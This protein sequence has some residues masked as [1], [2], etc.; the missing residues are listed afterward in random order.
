MD[1]YTERKVHKPLALKLPVGAP[2]TA[3]FVRFS[4]VGDSAGI[5]AQRAAHFSIYG[6]DAAVA[7]MASIPDDAWDPTRPEVGRAHGIVWLT[8]SDLHRNA[9]GREPVAAIVLVGGHLLASVT[10]S[11]TLKHV[12][13]DDGED[14]NGVT[15]LLL[16]LINHY[17]SLRAIRWADDVTRAQRDPADWALIKNKC[18]IRQITMVVGGRSY[19]MQDDGAEM[20]LGALGLVGSSDDPKRRRRLTGKRL[21]KYRT[22][23]AGIAESQL[24]HGW[25]FLRDKHGRP[26]IDDD[27]GRIPEAQPAMI[28]VMRSLYEAHAGGQTYRE[29][30]EQLV[31][32]E[33][34]GQLVRRDHTDPSSTYARTADDSLARYD[35]A[36][37]FFVR[38]SFRPATPPSDEAIECY[39]A[40]DDPQAVFD[41]ETRLYIAKVELVRTGTYF[42]RLRNDIRGRGL[43]LDGIPATYRDDQDEYGWFDVLSSPWSWPCDVEQRE[44]VRF[45]LTDSTCRQVAGRLLRELRRSSGAAGGGRSH[46]TARPRA[47]QHFENWLTEPGGEYADEPTE[48]GVEARENNSGRENF[49]LLFR[50][51]SEGGG[52]RGRR[53]WGFVGTGQRRADH[54][55]ATGNLA[56]LCASVSSSLESASRTLA[57]PSRVLLLHAVAPTEPVLDRKAALRHNLDRELA[58]MAEADRLAEGHRTMAALVAEDDPVEARK[59]AAAAVEAAR[60]A[61]RLGSR[62]EALQLELADAATPAGQPEE[63]VANVGLVPYVVVGLERAAASGGRSDERLA[64]VCGELFVGWEFSVVN[65]A[66]QWSCQCVLPLESGRSAHLPLAGTVRNV[67]TRSGRAFATTEVVMRHLMEEGQSVDYVAAVLD[68]SRSGLLVRRIMPWLASNGVV[69]RGAKCALVDH[70]LPAVRRL[71]YRQL[72]GVE[73][74]VN[75]AYVAR[76]QTTYT[77]PQLSW[78]D[79]AVPDDCVWIAAVLELLSRDADAHRNGLPLLD[80]ALAVGRTEREVRALVSPLDRSA[81]GFVRPR[82]LRYADAARSRVATLKCP[83]KS[84]RGRH[85]ADHV[86]LLPEVAA[87]GWGVICRKCRRV[88]ATTGD[89]PLTQFPEAYLRSWSRTTGVKSLRR[90]RQ[91]L[92]A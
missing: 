70:P 80:V 11:T 71:V 37:S 28:P 41:A 82:Y 39:L 60:S 59:Y 21:M 89:W 67:R 4:V 13:R 62:A 6:N 81:G 33:A 25:R 51:E 42:R 84:C 46:R 78:G 20:A 22:G 57:D 87:S 7:Q 48:W 63:D 35:A 72:N 74:A 55:A 1:Q 12:R 3:D 79:A 90:T 76:V 27:R 50:R 69:S 85:L 58:E 31:A 14:E 17:P 36:K 73:D 24:P 64:K 75:N 44:I 16:A 91:T 47:L 77:D 23:G 68:S 54:I 66:L 38:S 9:S 86:V 32:F 2:T 34:A 61:A 8:L 92:E 29:L 26:I 56:E 53:G 19:D 18:K 30:A 43:V 45:G 15:L 65:D 83:H 10:L 40:G 5:S 52:V 49:I 88:P